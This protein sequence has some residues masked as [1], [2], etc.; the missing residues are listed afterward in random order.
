MVVGAMMGAA[1]LEYRSQD[2]KNEKAH[3]R[4]KDL[5]QAFAARKADFSTN[6][7]KYSDEIKALIA[8]KKFDEARDKAKK[9]LQLDDGSMAALIKK[10]DAEQEPYL[11]AERSKQLAIMLKERAAAEKRDRAERKKHGVSIGMTMEEVVA[12]KWGHPTAI[13]STETP[14]GTTYQ[15][16]YSAGYVYFDEAGKVRTIQQRFGN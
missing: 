1:Y 8:D 12:S 4:A 11:A 16:V 7:M 9:W 14:R 5:A 6:K 10:A 2:A 13:N 15:W 3:A